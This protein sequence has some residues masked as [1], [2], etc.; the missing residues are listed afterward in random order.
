MK[1]TLSSQG[2]KNTS[3]HTNFR[4]SAL[5]FCRYFSNCGSK[6][7]NVSSRNLVYR[8][9]MLFSCDALSFLATNAF[10]TRAI[11][12]TRRD[13]YTFSFLGSE[14]GDVRENTKEMRQK[15]FIFVPNFYN[16]FLYT[17][18]TKKFPT[19][20]HYPIGPEIRRRYF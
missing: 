12:T 1:K 6:L 11:A 19:A 4:K 3:I 9:R 8:V 5:I 17:K 20:V 13:P 18:L 15:T 7:P 10:L 2:D 14:E 16:Y